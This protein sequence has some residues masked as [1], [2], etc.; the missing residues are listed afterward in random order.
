M[1]QPTDPG[2]PCL[3]RALLRRFLYEEADA[4]EEQRAH[5]HIADCAA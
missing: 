2:T 4:A 1:N 5:T 3:D